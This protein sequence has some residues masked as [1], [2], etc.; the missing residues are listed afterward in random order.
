MP[1][2]DCC[3]ELWEELRESVE[4]ERPRKLL[5]DFSLVE[6]GPIDVIIA[7]LIARKRVQSEGGFMKVYGL[8]DGVRETFRRLNLDRATSDTYATQAA[9][10]VAF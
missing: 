3:A 5:V 9:A 7:L 1:C 4:Q 2:I 8:N 10:T 6:Y